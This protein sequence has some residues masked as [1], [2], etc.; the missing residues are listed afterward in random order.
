M[1]RKW[2]GIRG[3]TL[4]TNL[5]EWPRWNLAQAA[6]RRESA[7][8]MLPVFEVKKEI[9]VYFS[10]PLNEPVQVYQPLS[11]LGTDYERRS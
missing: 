11:V 4:V 2:A 3:H 5:W 1:L 10:R 7:C 9:S 6:H 8:T